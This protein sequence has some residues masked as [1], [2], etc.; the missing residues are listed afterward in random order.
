M[1]WRRGGVRG[2]LCVLVLELNGLEVE[3]DYLML[4]IDRRWGICG[5][6]RDGMGRNGSGYSSESEVRVFQIAS[7][8]LW[9]GIHPAVTKDI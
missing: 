2:L 8:Y 7:S 6:V 3:V 9:I 4:V 1:G 5:A